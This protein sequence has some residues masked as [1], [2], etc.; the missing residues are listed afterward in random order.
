M[1][2]FQIFVLKLFLIMYYYIINNDLGNNI[3]Y[4]RF[5]LKKRIA[6]KDHHVGQFSYL[7]L[8]NTL[9][10]M[11]LYMYIHFETGRTDLP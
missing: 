8:L 2:I 3:R 10:S 5:L 9:F 7:K 6:S 11:S 1:I 4:G